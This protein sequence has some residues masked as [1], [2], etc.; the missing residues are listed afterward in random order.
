[1]SQRFRSV[2]DSAAAFIRILTIL[3]ALAAGTASDAAEESISKL[4]DALRGADEPA[5]IE[6]IDALGR[7]GPAAKSAVKDLTAQLSDPSPNVRAHAAH[8]RNR[9]ARR[10]RMPRLP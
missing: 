9:W 5:R 6:A 1:M 3:V 2:P 4:T 8:A 10:P 7:A